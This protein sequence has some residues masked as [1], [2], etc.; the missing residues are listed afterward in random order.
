MYFYAYLLNSNR[1]DALQ[2]EK[3]QDQIFKIFC[4]AFYECKRLP[5]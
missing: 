5:S 2:V 3:S 4:Q 1:I